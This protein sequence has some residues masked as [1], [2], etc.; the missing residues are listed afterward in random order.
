MAAIYMINYRN[1]F[2]NVN[3]HFQKKKK[4]CSEL[5]KT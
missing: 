4:K 5:N 1:I 2:T 3:K